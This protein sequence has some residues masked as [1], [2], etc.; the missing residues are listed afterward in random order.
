MRFHPKYKWQTRRI[1]IFGLIWLL[2]GL[3]YLVIE[4][5]LI[6]N[7]SYYP[8][9]GNSFDFSQSLFLVPMAS[10]LMGLFQGIIE[11]F[12]SFSFLN[13]RMLWERIAFKSTFY[14]VLITIF[15]LAT[16]LISNMINLDM[17]F[18]SRE[19][20]NSLNQFISQFAFWGIIIYLGFVVSMSLFY[21]EIESYI[22]KDIISNYFGKYHKPIKERRIF[23]F[24]DMKSST[25]IAE[26][27]GHELYFELLK[28]YYE[29][30]TN[31]VLETYGQIY[32][33]VGDE[34]VVTWKENIGITDNNC[35]KCF[36]KIDNAIKSNN[37]SYMEKFG[38]SLEFK[39]G[40][41]VGEVTAGEIGIIKKDIIYTGD[42]LNTTARIQ[43]EC[44]KYDAKSLI[45]DNLVQLLSEESLFYFDKKEQLVL[46]GKTKPIQLY[47]VV[48]V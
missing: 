29:D 31:A 17:P 36:I 43:S 33:Y 24:L 9:T 10:F 44:N 40:F 14:L 42:V 6:G 34:I 41:H 26:K 3:I 2:F 46:K 18:Y 45:S 15:L 37:S 47:E 27:I 20:L 32:Q 35:I 38:T 22:G 11:E 39:A 21:S 25:T 48:Y 30:M 19:V 8:S 7:L 5:G 12:C 1:L 23:M 28:T 13:N 4:Y 16:S